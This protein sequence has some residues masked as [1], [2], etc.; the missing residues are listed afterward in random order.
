MKQVLFSITA[1][2]LS[3]MVLAQKVSSNDFKVLEGN[4][5]G[6]LTYLDYTSNKQETIP[7]TLKASVTRSNKFEL[8]FGYP[9]ESGKGG[10][11]VYKISEDGSLV[12]NMKVLERTEQQ[13]GTLKIVLEQKGPDGNDHR[14]AT[15]HHILEI[16]KD[17]FVMTKMVK[18]DNEKNFFRRNQY[19]FSR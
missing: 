19:E 9:G 12:N 8:K 7:S 4:W 3:V 15:F 14:P 6:Q 13:D 11:D 1:L 17:K 5:T 16:G 10:A 18:F 2:F